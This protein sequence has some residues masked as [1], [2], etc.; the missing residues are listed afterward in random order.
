MPYAKVSLLV[1]VWKQPIF[2][3]FML[4]FLSL[5]L[6]FYFTLFHL[7]FYWLFWFWNLHVEG[8]ANKV[9][10]S[11]LRSKNR[12]NR[13]LHI[14]MVFLQILSREDWNFTL[15]SMRKISPGKGF[16]PVRFGNVWRRGL[17]RNNLYT[18]LRH[19]SRRH[20]KTANNFSKNPPL[21]ICIFPSSTGSY[22]ST[23]HLGYLDSLK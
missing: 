16:Y 6:N 12:Q 9:V 14:F 8:K 17:Y 11:L 13:S 23:W 7:L 20:E 4:L 5:L 21:R 22:I 19:A 15:W 18:S 3:W 10:Y 1:F 2:I